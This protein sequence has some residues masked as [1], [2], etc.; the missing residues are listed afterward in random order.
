MEDKIR[1]LLIDKVV[2]FTDDVPLKGQY[3][4]VLDVG[5]A[6]SRFWRQSPAQILFLGKKY[7]AVDRKK[8]FIKNFIFERCRF[9]NS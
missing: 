4:A 6:S 9:F 7:F 2:Y 8:I 1:T 5:E 3:S